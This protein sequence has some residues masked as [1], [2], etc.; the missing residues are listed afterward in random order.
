MSRLGFKIASN[1]G[2][3]WCEPSDPALKLLAG[4]HWIN[5]VL[6]IPVLSYL[7]LAVGA[8]KRLHLLTITGVGQWEMSALLR[9][10]RASGISP[11]V[12]L[13]HPFE[14]VKGDVPGGDR[15]RGNRVS[16]KS[17]CRFVAE[18]SE[19]YVAVSISEA[20]SRW[21]LHGSTDPPGLQGPILPALKTMLE[22]K[23]NELLR[24]L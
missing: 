23:A 20:A 11:V 2:L 4:R 19:D 24:W 17:L 18:N 22:N 9:R 5:G 16:L 13:T 14:Y 3:G 12:I 10:A 1:I 15:S 8:F 6:E 7:Q 21:T